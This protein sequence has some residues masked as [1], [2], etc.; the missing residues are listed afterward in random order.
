MTIATVQ[1]KLEA[2]R[3]LPQPTPE[4]QSYWDGTKVGELRVQRCNACAHTY[5]PPRPFCPKCASREV[6][7]IKASG[8]ATLYSYVI[9]HRPVPGFTPPYSI[10]V[11]ELEE[12]PRMMTN[13]I[14][15]PQTPE[16]LQLDMPL[17]V[18]F[19]TL[20]DTICLPQFK[21]AVVAR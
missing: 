13:I 11:V 18:T 7:W 6:T 14:G 16:A 12:G 1:S 3:S 2:R 5:F 9:H 21:P 17:Q 10:A 4:T 19:V 8:R 20:S 15:C